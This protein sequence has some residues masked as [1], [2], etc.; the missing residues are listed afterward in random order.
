MPA[1]TPSSTLISAAVAVTPSRIFNSAVVAV[2]PSSLLSSDPEAVTSVFPSLSPVVEPLWSLTWTIVPFVLFIP[3]IDKAVWELAPDGWT[4][5][6]ISEPVPEAP[7]RPLEY[8][9]PENWFPFLNLIDPAKSDEASAD[10]LCKTN[11][12]PW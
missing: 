12:G 7:P 4:L 10:E 3:V 2:T 11:W 6:Y 8:I 9:K 5:K 1:V